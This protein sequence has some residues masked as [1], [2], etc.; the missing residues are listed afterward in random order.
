[1]PQ[2]NGNV[3]QD[4]DFPFG[5]LKIEEHVPFL[6]VQGDNYQEPVHAPLFFPF[7]FHRAYRNLFPLT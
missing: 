1:M 4:I 2:R 5:T 3:A 7:F 6:F